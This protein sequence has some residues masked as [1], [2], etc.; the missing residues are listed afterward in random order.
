MGGA[1]IDM[2]KAV[3]AEI[4]GNTHIRSNTPC[5]DK[6]KSFTKDE[7]GIICL[8]DG[9]GSAKLSHIGAE[10]V[11]NFAI[12]YFS[13]NFQQLISEED[14]RKIKCDILTLLQER[15]LKKSNEENCDIKDLAATF[16]LVAIYRN[17]FIIAHVGD[18]VIGYLDGDTL[19]VASFPEHE[20][21]ANV[22]T[23]IT[24]KNALYSMK[25]IKGNIKN[26]AGF[27]LMSDGAEQSLYNK[28]LR[29]LSPAITKLF[30]CNCILPKSLMYDYLLKILESLISKKTQDDCSIAIIS[31][32]TPFLLNCSSF[33]ED[34]QLKLFNINPSSKNKKQQI[35][36]HR[37][38]MEY[39]VSPRTLKQVSMYTR[40]KPK[41]AIKYLNKLINCNMICKIGIFYFKA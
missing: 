31:R 11:T 36:R 34:M 1:R 6:T 30:R 38:I 41:C 19:K 23:F 21:F 7:I 22:T 37:E 40:I 28:S 39:L 12:E 3:S 24:S 10:I 9:A 15:L 29:I 5:Q 16:L 18:G 14:G 32:I 25:L 2:W 20:E 8:A 35:L 4:R 26:I 27:I 13:S 17:E 33:S